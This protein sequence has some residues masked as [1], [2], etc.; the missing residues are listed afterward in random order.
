MKAKAENEN[1]KEEPRPSARAMELSE[2]FKDTVPEPTR[3]Q[4]EEAQRNLEQT[5]DEI[6]NLTGRPKEESVQE[7]SERASMFRWEVEFAAI[8][9]GP[10]FRPKRLGEQ[11]RLIVNT[12][13]P[14]FTK[15]YDVNAEVKA[16]LEVLLFV[17]AE[18]ELESRSDAETFYKAERQK[19]SER[20]RH[21]LNTLTPTDS[22]TDRAAAVAEQMHVAM[23]NE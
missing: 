8:P 22:L 5:A 4:R 16:G 12:D 7:L 18:R 11:K 21:A 17:L 6:A 19:W 14:F 23:A 3:E 13:H 9:E 1:S 15:V 2:K 20:L 10:F